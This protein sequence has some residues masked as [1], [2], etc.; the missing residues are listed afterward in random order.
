ME[1]KLTMKLK[2]AITLCVAIV[3]GLGYLFF[4]PKKV[5]P[6]TQEPIAVAPI[7]SVD[8]NRTC[9]TC[10]EKVV[11]KR[12][13]YD[14]VSDNALL[15]IVSVDYPIDENYVP[16]HLR[17]VNVTSDHPQE[18]RRDAAE[19]LETM[20]EDASKAGVSLKL[21]SGYRDY[22]LQKSLWYTYVD[23]YGLKHANR[24]DDHPGASEHQ[25][26]LAVDL[27]WQN[28]ACVLRQCFGNDPNY[29]WLLDHAHEYGY[30]PRYPKGKE[31]I[32]KIMYS[33]WHFR[34][35]GERNAEK[36]HE[37]NQTMEEFYKEYLPKKK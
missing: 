35:V 19:H 22:T 29:Q 28:N 30:I 33:P 14:V 31:D 2:F 10:D 23:R 34:Y 16:D 12:E 3:V 24:I 13:A 27:G 5:K 6:E 15:R 8:P 37:A 21:L 26:G 11:K 20:F 36:L 32:T 25:L 4:A 17:V 7:E 9:K 18:L 1:D